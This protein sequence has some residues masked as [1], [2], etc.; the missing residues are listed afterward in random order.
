MARYLGPKWAPLV[1]PTTLNAN[2]IDK[3]I[4]G[5]MANISQIGNPT[6]GISDY[7]FL[8]AIKRNPLDRGPYPGTTLF[9]TANRALT[10]LAI[11]KGVK[12]LLDN[13]T[14]PFTDY[15][16]EYGNRNVNPHDIMAANGTL[17]LH[18]EAFNVA[19]SFFQGKKT[20]SLTKLRGGGA[21]SFKLI[22]A[23]S[24]ARGPGYTPR[25]R[26]GEHILLVDVDGSGPRSAF[27]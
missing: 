23:N 22:I 15:D 27:Y 10:D 21:A 7:V 5:C 2:N 12:W 8:K 18:G 4:E 26:A 11:L 13:G 9:E 16:V 19:K 3:A 25:L 6:S 17:T 20:S 14:F 1:L 24:D